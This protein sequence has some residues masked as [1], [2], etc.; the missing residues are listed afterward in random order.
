MPVVGWKVHRYHHEDKQVEV[1]IE[2]VRSIF[3]AIDFKRK[4]FISLYN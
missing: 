2:T 1:V 3:L 4:M